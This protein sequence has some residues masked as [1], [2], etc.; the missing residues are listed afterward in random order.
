MMERVI[1]DTDGM[2]STEQPL[3]QSLNRRTSCGSPGPGEWDLFVPPNES[4]IPSSGTTIEIAIQTICQ[5]LDESQIIVEEK[6][7]FVLQ[8]PAA[9]TWGSLA[10]KAISFNT[11]KNGPEATAFGINKLNP[12]EPPNWIQTIIGLRRGAFKRCSCGVVPVHYK[13]RLGDYM[14]TVTRD[15]Y[16]CLEGYSSCEIPTHSDWQD[17]LNATQ[18]RRDVIELFKS[19]ISLPMRSIVFALY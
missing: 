5:F 10:N 3:L 4:S 13:G 11:K 17:E 2:R 16:K 12:G 15:E 1:S 14:A 6:K 18:E 7:S 19:G 9:D 8:D